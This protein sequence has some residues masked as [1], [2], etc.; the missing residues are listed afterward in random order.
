MTSVKVII[1]YSQP[2]LVIWHKM[3]MMVSA[4]DSMEEEK[5]STFLWDNLLHFY[6]LCSC[7][8]LNSTTLPPYLPVDRSLGR[9]AGSG[10]EIFQCHSNMPAGDSQEKSL[11]SQSSHSDSMAIQ[12]RTR[13]AS[14][15]DKEK[16]G[17]FNAHAFTFLILWYFFSACTLFLNKYILATLRSDPTLLGECG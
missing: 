4:Q 2:P 6:F 15:V 13:K 12:H 16:L 9:L 14:T 5:V 8:V 1:H 3:M 10:V 11:L 7:D 17:L